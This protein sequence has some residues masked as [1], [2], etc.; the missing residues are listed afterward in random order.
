MEKLSFFQNKKERVLL[1]SFLSLLFFIN[2]SNS[3]NNYLK[4]TNEE[5]F[6]TKAYILNSYSKKDYFVLKI[7]TDN[8]TCYTTTK[9]NYEIYQN[10]Y[11][12]LITK[13]INFYDYL[14]GFYTNSFN[15]NYFNNKKTNS[16]KNK[17]ANY[18]K[19]QH[20]DNLTQSLY[21]A[22]YLAKPISQDLRTIVSNYG[23]S[24]LIAISGFHL[25]IIVAVLYF[26]I[27]LIYSPI[28]QR[29]IPYRNK[30]V[31]VILLSTFILF[32]YLILIDISPSFLRSFVMFIL[33]FY[34]LRSNIKLISFETLLIITVTI[35]ALFPSLIFSLGLWL[36]VI[37][38]FYIFLFIKY[39]NKLHKYLQFIL[40]NYWLFFA[41]NPIVHYIF[42]TTSKEQL[43]SL[44]ITVLF[45]LFYPI[46]LLCHIS[47]Y[48]NLFDEILISIPNIKITSYEIITPLWL[49]ISY[50]IISL[51]SIW[52]RVSF[53]ILNIILVLFNSYLF[54]R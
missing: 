40:F 41:M 13:D 30:K 34:L 17:I 35:I 52:Y 53:I 29:Y 42:Y 31:D 38:V 54:F 4:F 32:L 21:Q 11:L 6:N 20:S 3:Y 45:S 12:S 22:L 43:Y 9:K 36:S 25:G 27:N 39:F 48:G 51:L 15:I 18:I 33:G 7:K 2:I 28:H 5:I 10:I 8:F 24:H 19:E 23:I 49:F 44:I 50:I 16:I 26:I 47:N 14:K 1:Y 46:T 37:G